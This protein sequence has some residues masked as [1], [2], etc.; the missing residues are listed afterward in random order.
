MTEIRE[1]LTMSKFT[2]TNTLNPY[3]GAREQNIY[4][5]N[6]ILELAIEPFLI[7][8]LLSSLAA[9]SAGTL[10]LPTLACG[11]QQNLGNT[12]VYEGNTD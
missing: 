9:Y 1:L 6:S 8:C 3:Q 2:L 7:R 5:T 10:W 12:T 11:A 4:L